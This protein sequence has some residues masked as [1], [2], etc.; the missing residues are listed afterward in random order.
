[1]F[2]WLPNLVVCKVV[3]LLQATIIGQLAHCNTIHAYFKENCVA[4]YYKNVNNNNNNKKKKKKKKIA[5]NYFV[6]FGI[7]YG[8]E[9]LYNKVGN[10]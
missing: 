1:M 6:T 8:S 5:E 10:H 3:K 4:E 7:F 2:G 9:E